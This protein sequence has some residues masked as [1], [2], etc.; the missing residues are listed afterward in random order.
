MVFLHWAA[1]APW[2]EHEPKAALRSRSCSRRFRKGGTSIGQTTLAP[3]RAATGA[4]GTGHWQALTEY[5]TF[6]VWPEVATK[7][8][9]L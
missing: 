6:P 8:A 4:A 9:S 1:A 5:I 3:L 7:L 2:S